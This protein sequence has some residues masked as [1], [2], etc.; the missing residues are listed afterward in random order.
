MLWAS[1]TLRSTMSFFFF[2]LVVFMKK[3]KSP[4]RSI[5]RLIDVMIPIH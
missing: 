2:L 4:F 1:S 3:K 5:H